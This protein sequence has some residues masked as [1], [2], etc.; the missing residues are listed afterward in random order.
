MAKFWNKLKKNT[1]PAVAVHHIDSEPMADNG[2]PAQETEP[3]NTNTGTSNVKK[4]AI[5]VGEKAGE[6]A[7]EVKEVV[8]EQ[9]KKIASTVVE[10]TGEAVV[11]SKSRIKIYNLNHQLEKLYAE[12]GGNVYELLKNKETAV[13][14]NAAV[15]LTLDKIDMI[16]EEISLINSDLDQNR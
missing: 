15:L 5:K 14:K 13:L 3:E 9:S 2:V 7:G 10:K 4:R 1:E 12:V 8:V 11:Y 16:K 6:K